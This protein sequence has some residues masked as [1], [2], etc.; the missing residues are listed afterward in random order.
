MEK[1]FTL[2]PFQSSHSNRP[3]VRT[4]S[5]HSNCGVPNYQVF[6]RVGTFLEFSKLLLSISKIPLGGAKKYLNSIQLYIWPKYPNFLKSY[7]KISSLEWI[8][9]I[10]MNAKVSLNTYRLLWMIMKTISKRFIS[11][12]SDSSK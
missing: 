10:Q 7:W 6:F 11:I 5:C 12:F 8:I 2:P 1:Y 4:D 3:V 9:T